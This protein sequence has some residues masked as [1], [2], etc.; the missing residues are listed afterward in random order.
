[1]AALAVARGA[2]PVRANNTKLGESLY[3]GPPGAPQKAPLSPCDANPQLAALVLSDSY[4][5]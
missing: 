1:M 2:L 5:D 4:G 3:G